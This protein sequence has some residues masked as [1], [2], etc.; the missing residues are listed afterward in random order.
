VRTPALHVFQYLLLLL[1]ALSSYDSLHIQT[2][3][4]TASYT[5]ECDS[6]S[7]VSL[8]TVALIAVAVTCALFLP[9]IKQ[10]IEYTR[11]ETYCWHYQTALRAPLSASQSS[12]MNVSLYNIDIT[13]QKADIGRG[14]RILTID[15]GQFH[16]NTAAAMLMCLEKRLGTRFCDM[17]D[18]VL[19]KH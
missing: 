13:P 10:M 19:G 7:W 9:R 1:I 18:L 2:V 4:V 3:T 8:L 5:M 11:F 17:F 15:G 12:F 16:Y 14:I 6:C